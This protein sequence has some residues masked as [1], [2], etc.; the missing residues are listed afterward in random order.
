MISFKNGRYLTYDT[1]G[2]FIEVPTTDE[3]CEA[4]KARIDR[5]EQREE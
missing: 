4:I 3:I 1:A 2:K 5:A